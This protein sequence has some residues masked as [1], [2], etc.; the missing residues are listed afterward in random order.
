MLQKN[1]SFPVVSVALK[2]SRSFSTHLKSSLIYLGYQENLRITVPLP[3]I[4]ELTDGTIG[5][6]AMQA[7]HSLVWMYLD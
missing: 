2:Q 7:L 6:A 1:L 5:L 3:I 4:H